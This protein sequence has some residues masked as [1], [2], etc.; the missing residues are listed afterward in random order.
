MSL[1]QINTTEESDVRE[2]SLRQ[3][4]PEGFVEGSESQM[5]SESPRSKGPPSSSTRRHSDEQPPPGNSSTGGMSLKHKGKSVSLQDLKVGTGEKNLQHWNTIQEQSSEDRTLSQH[6]PL[7]S[8]EYVG[9]REGEAR[10]PESRR[11]S[12]EVDPPHRK[13][14]S[15]ESNTSHPRSRPEQVSPLPSFPMLDEDLTAQLYWDQERVPY[16]MHFIENSQISQAGGVGTDMTFLTDLKFNTPSEFSQQN[17]SQSPTQH[18]L[19]DQN[20]LN[21]PDIQIGLVEEP[22]NLSQSSNFAN[23][24]DS[25]WES[26][27]TSQRVQTREV[28]SQQTTRSRRTRQAPGLQTSLC[29]ALQEP[30]QPH[31]GRGHSSQLEGPDTRHATSHL[32]VRRHYHRQQHQQHQQHHHSHHHQQRGQHYRSH[33]RLHPGSRSMSSSSLN[34]NKHR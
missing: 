26:S 31:P 27:Q 4:P 29:S 7:A 34:N 22:H 6:T 30:L 3:V 23:S 21:L 15:V 20:T 1:V 16:P 17:R 19:T 11:E 9:P 28:H 32:S 25:L 12:W 14:Q 8:Q 2:L 24:Q 10:E 5:P 33:E 18:L 13:S